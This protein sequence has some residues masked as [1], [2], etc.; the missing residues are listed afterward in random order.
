MGDTTGIM[1]VSKSGEMFTVDILKFYKAVQ[2]FVSKG[3]K[4]WSDLNGL[5]HPV[6]FRKKFDSNVMG[7]LRKALGY[8]SKANKIKKYLDRI[9]KSKLKVLAL[10]SRVQ[11]AIGKNLVNRKIISQHGLKKTISL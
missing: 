1:K 5:K 3:L 2:K 8:K 10:Q 6:G 4:A 11:G 7:G 9:Q